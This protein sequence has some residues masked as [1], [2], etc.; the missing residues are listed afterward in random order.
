MCS[1]SPLSQMFKMAICIVFCTSPALTIMSNA[2]LKTIDDISNS[3]SVYGAIAIS[4][5]MQL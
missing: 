4:M 3:D 1:G 2:K 5:I